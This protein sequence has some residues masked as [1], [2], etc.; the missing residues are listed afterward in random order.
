MRFLHSG[1]IGDEQEW[2]ARHYPSA[3]AAAVVTRPAP[4]TGRTWITK[5]TWSYSNDPAGG[6][7]WIQDGATV[8]FDIDITRGGPGSLQFNN[9]GRSSPGNALTVTLAAGGAGIVGKLNVEGL[10]R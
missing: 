10:T 1:A 5:A 7:L 6:R 2:T 3:N 8:I 9:D 4:A